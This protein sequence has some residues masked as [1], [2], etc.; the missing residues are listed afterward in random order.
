M[1]CPFARRMVRIFKEFEFTYHDDTEPPDK[2]KL[3]SALNDLIKFVAEDGKDDSEVRSG[4][5]TVGCEYN[6]ESGYLPI[7][8]MEI[9]A[10]DTL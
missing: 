5:F 10:E 8:R 4:R 3:L 9:D 7:M 2:N 1:A 6:N